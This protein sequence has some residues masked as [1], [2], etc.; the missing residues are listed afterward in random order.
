[1]APMTRS[2]APGNIPTALMAEYYGQRAGAGLIIT[3]GTSP[4]PNGLGYTNIPGIYNKEQTDAWK[5][6]TAAV[7]AKGGHIFVQLM[8]TGRITHALNLPEGSKVIAPSAIQAKGQ[9]YT[10]EGMKPLPVPE[11][12][13]LTEI[14]LAQ[15]EFVNASINA[16]SA[17]FDGVEMHAA[18]GYLLEEF[19]SP[20]S[21]QRIDKYGGS[22]EN[23]CRFVLEVAEE[24]AEAIGKDKV[25]LRISPYGRN[26]DMEPYEDLEETYRSL[27]RGLDDIGIV[28]LHVA[29]PP[30][31]A[32][33]TLPEETKQMLRNEF[34]GTLIFCGGHTP[35]SAEKD[36]R[37]GM[38]DLIAFGKLFIS[39]PDLAERIQN[40]YPLDNKADTATFYSGSVKGYTDY[41]VWNPGN[42]TK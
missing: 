21:N 36:L 4:S 28:Y 38:P 5:P 8:H 13:D 29:L 37:Q 10:A 30:L 40:N 7:H 20:R 42:S 26:G 15:A 23:R 12:M 11:E 1:M 16:I 27:V 34:S 32:T 31:G 19:L 33:Y 22:P 17:G 39:N 35:E 18:N 2:R 9:M 24:I 41:P 25:G 6:V 3:E 14:E